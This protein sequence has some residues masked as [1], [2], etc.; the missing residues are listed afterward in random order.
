LVKREMPGGENASK[1][2]SERIDSSSS[3]TR[4]GWKSG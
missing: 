1:K 4:C 3:S 2:Q